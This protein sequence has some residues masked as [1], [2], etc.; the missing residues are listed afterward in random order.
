MPSNLLIESL[1]SVKIPV[2][3]KN[4]SPHRKPVSPKACPHLDPFL[5]FLGKWCENLIRQDI[6]VLVLL[7]KGLSLADNVQ[8]RQVKKYFF[9]ASGRSLSIEVP[10]QL[11]E[12][13]H[14]QLLNLPE[15]HLHKSAA[16]CWFLSSSSGWNQTVSGSR[17]GQPLSPQQWQSWWQ[18]ADTQALSGGGSLSLEHRCSKCNI[19]EGFSS[20]FSPATTISLTHTAVFKTSK[21]FLWNMWYLDFT[22][23]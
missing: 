10:K 14:S 3:E 2:V 13:A 16:Q 22:C 11:A 23:K 5:L 9:I 6:K 1:S 21:S 7:Q 4:N 18:M 17:M 8:I 19:W 15:H 20:W 12:S